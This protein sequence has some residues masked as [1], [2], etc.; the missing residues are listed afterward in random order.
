[1]QIGSRTIK[2]AKPFYLL[3]LSIYFIRLYLLYYLTTQYQLLTTQ[4]NRASISCRT[5]QPPTLASFPT[6]G[7]EQELVA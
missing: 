5:A 6:W 2:K 4:K 1:M 3:C 7:S